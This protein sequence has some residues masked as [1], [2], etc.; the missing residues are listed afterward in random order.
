MSKE[1]NN[2]SEEWAERMI[3]TKNLC[4]YCKYELRPEDE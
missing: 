4:L 2:E 3:K 1:N